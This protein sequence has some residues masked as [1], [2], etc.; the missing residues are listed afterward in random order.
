MRRK[1]SALAVGAALSLAAFTGQARA[2]FGY[3]YYPQGY[4]GYGWGGWGGGIG[5]TAQGDIARGLGYFNIGAGQYNKDTAVANSIDTDTAMRWNQYVYESQREANRTYYNRKNDGI[6]RDQAAYDSMMKRMQDDPSPRD[7]ESGDALNAALDQLSDPRIHSSVLRT[8]SEPIDAK[9][10]RDLPFRSATEAITFSLTQLKASSQWPAALLEP[11]FEP[12]RKDFETLVDEVHKENAEK[13]EVSPR[14]LADIRGVN[15]RI[16]D[17]LTAM[18]LSSQAEQREAM[19][20]VKTT[21]ALT[22]MLERPDIDK[23]LGELSKI[24]RTTVGNLLSFMQTFNLRFGPATT[25]TQRQ[26]Y[27]ALYPELDKTRDRIIKDAQLDGPTAS[28]SGKGRLHDFFSAMDID[29]IQGRRR[30]QPTA[31]GAGGTDAAPGGTGDAAN[32]APGAQGGSGTT[33][34]PPPPAPGDSAPPRP[35]ENRQPK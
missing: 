27:A 19:N 30:D 17:K 13:G 14:T 7:I 3:G 25:A 11:R 10:I 34:A 1:I 18:P 16:R 29:Q 2:Q 35:R 23:V 15:N 28:G 5:G 31:N 24:D 20:F 22:R 26:A 4:G 6:A 8:A 9:L 12:E 33:P 32:A 21:T